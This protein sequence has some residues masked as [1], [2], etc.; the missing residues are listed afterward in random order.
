VAAHRGGRGWR[1]TDLNPYPYQL[2]FLSADM[3]IFRV[4]GYFVLVAIFT[5]DRVR[6]RYIDT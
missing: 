4:R 5:S 6:F 3:R 1:R 2:G